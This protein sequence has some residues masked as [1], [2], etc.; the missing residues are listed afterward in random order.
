MAR[1]QKY[2]CLNCGERFEL[3]VYSPEEQREERRRR[4]IYFDPI[5]CPACKRIDFREGWD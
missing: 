3:D 2:R 5:R 4:E 1:K